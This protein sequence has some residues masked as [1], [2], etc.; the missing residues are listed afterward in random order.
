MLGKLDIEYLGKKEP[1]FLPDTVFIWVGS[2][3]AKIIKVLEA[4]P[5]CLDHLGL[6]RNFLNK[7]VGK[8]D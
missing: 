6:D 4:N 2:V 5:E 7:T 3:Y 1:W 8:L